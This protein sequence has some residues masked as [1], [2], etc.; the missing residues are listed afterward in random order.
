MDIGKPQRVIIVEPLDVPT[1]A[2]EPLEEPAPASEA[3]AEP[4][5]RAHRTERAPA[6][7]GRRA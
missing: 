4:S 6:H 7:D 5:H 3:T 2:P 1:D